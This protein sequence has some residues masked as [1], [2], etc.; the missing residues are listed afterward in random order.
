M[1]SSGGGGT[2]AQERIIGAV[3]NKCSYSYGERR[4]MVALNGVT[5][6]EPHLIGPGMDFIGQWK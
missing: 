1:R 4:G 2:E 3:A 5:V 6:V